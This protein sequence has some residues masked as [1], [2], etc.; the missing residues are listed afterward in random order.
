[1]PKQK[2]SKKSR[3]SRTK[4][5]PAKRNEHAAGIDIGAEV[6]YVA[7]SELDKIP[8]LLSI[9]GKVIGANL[10]TIVSLVDAKDGTPVAQMAA[11]GNG[12]EQAL[13]QQLIEN[14]PAER[15]AGTVIA[16]DA[17]YSQ[18]ELVKTIVHDKGAHVLFQ[19]KNNQPTSNAIADKIFE[20]NSPLFWIHP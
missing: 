5:A 14:L 17:L 20:Q 11:P 16:G 8:D 4:T 9:D 15:I 13:S 6:H 19:L 12:K 3:Y 1:M 18:K 2:T 7:V 10:A